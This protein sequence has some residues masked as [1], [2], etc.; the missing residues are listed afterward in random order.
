MGLGALV[1]VGGGGTKERKGGR[2]YFWVED[3][4]KCLVPVV[5]G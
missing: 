4:E 5:V 1:E 2:G 3:V